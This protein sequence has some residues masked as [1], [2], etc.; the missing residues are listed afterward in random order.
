MLL[1]VLHEIDEER[2]LTI[3][4][5]K[6]KIEDDQY[7]TVIP[8]KTMEKKLKQVSEEEE[9]GYYITNDPKMLTFWFI[10]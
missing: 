4:V 8:E 10:N 2:P 7:E 3:T 9:S 1:K 6:L 5:K